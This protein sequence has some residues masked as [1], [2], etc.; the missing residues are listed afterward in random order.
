MRPVSSAC[1]FSSLIQLLGGRWETVG[2]QNLTEV[3]IYQGNKKK[4]ER[5]KE[6][7]G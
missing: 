4:E 6:A 5:G 3:G 2:E 1:D 7:E